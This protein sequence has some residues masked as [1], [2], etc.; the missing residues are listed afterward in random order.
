MSGGGP[1]GGRH[2]SPSG[3]AQPQD[4]S[5][6]F[7]SEQGA[8]ADGDYASAAEEAEAEVLVLPKVSY[9]ENTGKEM[10]VPQEV[11]DAVDEFVVPVGYARTGS[12]SVAYLY[13]WGVNIVPQGH[14]PTGERTKKWMCLASATCRT[15]S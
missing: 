8:N 1:S 5:T 12:T 14:D 2:R 10:V 6:S 4:H 3:T 9:N 13:S 15:S 11:R 7:A